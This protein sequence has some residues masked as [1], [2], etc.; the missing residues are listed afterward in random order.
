MQR[1]LGNVSSHVEGA[2]GERVELARENLLEALDRVL[3]LHEA[4][5][6]AREHLGHVEGL[7]HEALGLAG[8]G[9]GELVV[10]GKL[11]HTKNGNDVLEVLVALKHLLHLVCNHVVLLT[12]DFWSKCC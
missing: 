4:A 12:H 5:A 10:L 11:V 9:H 8:A 1:T 2:L 6:T 7:A 3:E